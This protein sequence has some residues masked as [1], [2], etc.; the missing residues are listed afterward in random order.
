M[1]GQDKS[2]TSKTG[3]KQILKV[4]VGKK[5]VVSVATIG[6]LCRA[7]LVFLRFSTLKLIS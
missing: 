7:S 4:T 6:L 5:N 3:T 1:R 2:H